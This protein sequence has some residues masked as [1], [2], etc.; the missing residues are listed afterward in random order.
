MGPNAI[1]PVSSD[2]ERL[3]KSFQLSRGIARCRAKALP[4]GGGP[5]DSTDSEER[6]GSV[7]YISLDLVG[8]A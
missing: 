8:L 5:D 6:G 7:I 3:L 4:G 2:R 1:M